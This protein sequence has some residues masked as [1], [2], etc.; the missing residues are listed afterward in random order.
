MIVIGFPGIGK[1]SVANKPIDGFTFSGYI[2]LE[3]SNFNKTYNEW[4]KDYCKVAIDL[5]KQGYCV[6]VSSHKEV[7]DYLSQY[8]DVEYIVSIFPSASLHDNWLDR[9]LTRYMSDHEEKHNR[10]FEYM[11]NNY[12]TVVESM[13][14]DDIVNKYKL[15]KNDNLDDLKSTLEKLNDWGVC[16]HED[17]RENEP[18][19]EYDERVFFGI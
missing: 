3:S 10:A 19:C 6:F 18:D 14:Q 11:S 15:T 13:E 1:S 8:Q 2:D 9:L 4:Y 17:R 12:Y 16:K 7:R 5:S